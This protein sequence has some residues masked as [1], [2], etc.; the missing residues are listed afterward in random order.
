MGRLFVSGSLVVAG[1]AALIEDDA[2]RPS[3]DLPAYEMLR[4][5]AWALVV[6]GILLAIT[7]LIRYLDN[8][9]PDSAVIPAN[10][11][12]HVTWPPTRLDV[13][14]LI[15]TGVAAFAAVEREWIMLGIALFTVLIA[16]VLPLMR[17]QFVLRPG[18]L[19][20][21]FDNP[22]HR[23][24][25]PQ[26]IW[27]VRLRNRLSEWFSKYRQVRVSKNSRTARRPALPIDGLYGEAPLVRRPLSDS[28][29]AA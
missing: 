15:A 2:S 7:S 1:I 22:T 16:V 27:Y 24:G 12:V 10:D 25:T 20:G 14:S 6:F 13:F 9:P 5:G 23:P 11:P 17:G 29:R 28:H 18:E 3:L 26:E 19:I 4:I 21:E 8:Q